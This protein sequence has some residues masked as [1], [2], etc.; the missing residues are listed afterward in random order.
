MICD[1]GGRL[2]LGIPILF[3]EHDPLQF[4]SQAADFC[5]SLRKL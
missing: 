4:R 2:I 1:G 3:V 5:V